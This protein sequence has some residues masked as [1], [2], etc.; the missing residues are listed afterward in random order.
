MKPLILCCFNWY[1]KNFGLNYRYT[2]KSDWVKK[3]GFYEDYEEGVV[4]NKERQKKELS[5]EE[6]KNT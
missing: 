1:R 5:Y 6:L 3:Y 2:S 4:K